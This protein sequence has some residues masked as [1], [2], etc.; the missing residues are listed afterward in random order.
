MI[1]RLTGEMAE[2]ATGIHA[3]AL[4]A[5]AASAYWALWADVRMQFARRDR[6]PHHW[7]V[8]G[9]AAT[10]SGRSREPLGNVGLEPAA[11]RA[12]RPGSSR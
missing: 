3:L 2:A 11:Q 4:E 8:F 5:A 1:D 7:C 9:I 12:G 6:V 10:V